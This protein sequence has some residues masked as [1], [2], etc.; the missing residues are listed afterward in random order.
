GKYYSMTNLKSGD[1]YDKFGRTYLFDLN[2]YYLDNDCKYTID[3]YHA[4]NFTRFLNHSCDPNAM[5]S[6]V[7]IDEADIYKPLLCIF[8]RRD[9]TPNEEITF[10][11][12]GDPDVDDDEEEVARKKKG[13][14]SKASPR[15]P[16]AGANV[17]KPCR[18]GA[19]NC[20]GVMWR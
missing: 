2:M 7:Y 19:K 8:A 17:H 16:K 6:F 13:A 5:L 14:K 3:A 4:G 11:Y 15:K 9:I 20:K 12:A 1:S 18:C 10:S